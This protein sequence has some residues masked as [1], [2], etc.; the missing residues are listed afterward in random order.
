MLST[1]GERAEQV[2]EFIS[3]DEARDR[4]LAAIRARRGT[5]ERLAQIEKLQAPKE[6]TATGCAS[7]E[8]DY[9]A[10]GPSRVA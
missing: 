8:R 2:A 5:P 10:R 1:L 7:R 6:Q 3:D 4:R 9:A